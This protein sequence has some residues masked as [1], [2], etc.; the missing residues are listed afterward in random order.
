MAS[1]KKRINLRK[2]PRVARAVSKLRAARAEL[3]RERKKLEAYQRRHAR[4]LRELEKGG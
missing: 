1:K 3:R 2:Y 4:E